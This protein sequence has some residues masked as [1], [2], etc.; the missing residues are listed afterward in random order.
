MKVRPFLVLWIALSIVYDEILVK[1]EWET[2]VFNQNHILHTMIQHNKNPKWIKTFINKSE[3]LLQP[4]DK[5]TKDAKTRIKKNVSC[6]IV[7]DQN[8]SANI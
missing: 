8:N 5:H 6:G 7:S 2:L 1:K 4:K 3:K